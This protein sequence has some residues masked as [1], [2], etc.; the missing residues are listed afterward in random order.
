M[1]QQGQAV[2][3]ICIHIYIYSSVVQQG[4]AVLHT[5][6]GLGLGLGLGAAG[7]G[8]PIQGETRTHGSQQAC[9][10]ILLGL[11][12]HTTRALPGVC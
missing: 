10:G 12:R 2:L 1:V 7:S 3:Y 6:L 4:Q 11:P 9:L 5:V 8:R